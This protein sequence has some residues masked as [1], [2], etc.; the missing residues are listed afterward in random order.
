[1]DVA[2]LDQ[3]GR[4]KG[5]AGGGAVACGVALLLS[6]GAILSPRAAWSE[7]LEAIL[8]R[9]NDLRAKGR[10]RQALE[11]FQRA[12]LISDSPRVTAQI[13]L[14]EQALGLWVEA[15]V[16]ITKA[17]AA[18]DDPWIAKNR[19]ALERAR[20]TI[21][22][23]V[24]TVEIWGTPD[25]AEV[26]VD[27]K[28]VGRLP[29]VGPVGVAADEVE[30]QVRAPGYVDSNRTLR[31]HIGSLVREHVDLR[32]S[33]RA[34]MEE[35]P[36]AATGRLE[37]QPN[38]PPP[39]P[40]NDVGA[41]GPHD[42]PPPSASPS[43]RTPLVLALS[44]VAVAALGFGVFEHVTWRNKVSSFGSMECDAARSDRGGAPCAQLY[45]AGNQAHTLAIA[46]YVAGGALAVTALII[47]LTQPDDLPGNQARVAC[48]IAPRSSG[49]DCI[50]RF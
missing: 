34:V 11:E 22:E 38:E 45:D 23:H 46:G 36:G 26:L 44:G 17:L 49:I 25:G 3:G 21:R 39:R 32:K 9:G 27:G 48:A 18:N 5:F 42:V 29:D 6:L 24:A 15:S 37:P 12:A 40:R 1:L 43:S 30:L 2:Q 31:T 41:A 8:K 7:D 33:A 16:D 50:M 13:A 10:D 19:V 14:A 28:V 4:L 20:G 35:S 47:H